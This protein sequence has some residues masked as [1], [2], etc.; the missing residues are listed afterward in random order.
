[1]HKWNRAPQR[2]HAWKAQHRHGD[3]VFAHIS[4]SVTVLIGWELCRQQGPSTTPALFHG[5]GRG[6]KRCLN[7]PTN[8]FDFD[9]DVAMCSI[10][11]TIVIGNHSMTGQDGDVGEHSLSA[12]TRSRSVHVHMLRRLRNSLTTSS[13]LSNVAI[14]FA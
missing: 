1:M 6:R 2:W 13:L 10:S 9:V 4:D 3:L 5:R 12:T 11:S 14:T 8:R 7:V